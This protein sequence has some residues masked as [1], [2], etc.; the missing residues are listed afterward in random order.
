[1]KSYDYVNLAISKD[2]FKPNL[3]DVYRDKES[4]VATDG[5]RIHWTNGL[6]PI[7]QG[8]YI[9]GGDSQFPEWQLALPQNIYSLSIYFSKNHYK[10]LTARLK[11][12]DK[13]QIVK[14]SFNIDKKLIIT[15]NQFKYELD[16]LVGIPPIDITFSINL[17]YLLSA[18]TPQKNEIMGGFDL[19]FD[20]PTTPIRLSIANKYNACIALVKE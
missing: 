10:D 11:L 17:A 13:K 8:Y 19:Y 20:N 9:S 6:P 2:K 1:M 3:N 14:I 12:L 5:H 15:S 7:E 18:L 16:I 4:L